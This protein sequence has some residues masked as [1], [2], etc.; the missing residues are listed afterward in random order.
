MMKKN[1]LLIPYCVAVEFMI[2]LL[3]LFKLQ[4]G[5]AINNVTAHTIIMSLNNKALNEAELVVL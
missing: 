3:V 1:E 4:I 5:I 2:F